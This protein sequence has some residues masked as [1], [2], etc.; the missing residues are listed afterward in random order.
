M[1]KEEIIDKAEE[2]VKCLYY[3][4]ARSKKEAVQLI[5]DFYDSI[6]TELSGQEEGSEK[7]L[8]RMLEA[9]FEGGAMLG[10][11]GDDH[12]DMCKEQF[13][14]S[15]FIEWYKLRKKDFASQFQQEDKISDEA[16]WE[17]EDGDQFGSYGVHGS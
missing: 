12:T 8:L 7:E 13:G 6:A 16:K 4:V 14:Y 3:P 2:F 17:D 9:S 5:I 11:F 1:K 15:C 10:Y